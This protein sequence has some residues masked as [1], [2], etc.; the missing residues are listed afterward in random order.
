LILAELYRDYV[1]PMNKEVQV[2]Y[3]MQRLDQE[4]IAY[5]S[6][7]AYEGSGYKA[8]VELFGTKIPFR[9]VSTI[10][11]AFGAILSNEV[12]HAVVPIEKDNQICRATQQALMANNLLISAEHYFQETNER[13]FLISKL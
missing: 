3:L 12:D 6:E 8:A 1:M 4:T 7:I 9:R 2:A 10:N 11:N 13:F 5:V